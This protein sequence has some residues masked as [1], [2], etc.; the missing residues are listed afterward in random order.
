MN[1]KKVLAAVLAVMMAVSAM[2]ITAFADDYKIDL[3]QNK[4]VNKITTTLTFELPVYALYGYMTPEYALELNLPKSYTQ[5]NDGLGNFDV[6]WSIVV[7]GT[8]YGLKPVK[9][10]D[11][12]GGAASV[13]TQYVNF[14]FLTHDYVSLNGTDVWATIP[15]STLVNDVTSVQLVA[16]MTYPSNIANYEDWKIN[17]DFYKVYPWATGAYAYVANAKVVKADTLEEVTNSISYSKDWNVAKTSEGGV[18][19]A[20]YEFCSGE[21]T[22]SGTIT[23]YDSIIPLTWDHTLANKAQILGAETIQIVVKLNKAINGQATYTL[24]GRKDVDGNQNGSNSKDWWQTWTLNADNTVIDEVKVDGS[25]EELVFD[26]PLSALYNDV[27]GNWNME[28]AIFENITLDSALL[29]T[30]DKIETVLTCPENTD[31]NLKCEEST[32]APLTCEES[33]DAVLSCGKDE[34]TT[35]LT[36][37]VELCAIEKDTKV[38]DVVCN[39]VVELVCET[40]KELT[41]TTDEGT[42]VDVCGADHSHGTACFAVHSHTDACYIAHEHDAECYVAHTHTDACTKKTVEV[43]HVHTEECHVEH[44][45]VKCYGDHDHVD[46]CYTAHVHGDD[47]YGEAHEHDANCYVD[48]HVHTDACYTSTIVYGVNSLVVD[49]ATFGGNGSL[50]DFAWSQYGGGTTWRGAALNYAKGGNSAGDVVAAEMYILLTS[51]DDAVIEDVEEPVEPST[52]EE[53]DETV[54][55]EPTEEPEN[56]TNPETGLAL[57]LVPMMVA[58]VAVVA[59]KRR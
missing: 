51:S 47:C 18:D 33:T 55:A 54:P 40:T 20:T 6:N 37:E 4:D 14:G 2:A 15:Q 45:V 27:Y 13:Y 29:G 28:F 11:L 3:Y 21:I 48:G 50:G 56:D 36:C 16:T 22:S 49:Y 23:D 57:A 34:V 1:M 42:L 35:Y 32:D 12:G 26:L 52:E 30:T 41:C 59:S 44:D 25:V 58:A 31:D 39:E 43:A 8:S 5:W 38:E 17:T 9:N 53:E 10:T 7:N 24:V 46:A 19:V